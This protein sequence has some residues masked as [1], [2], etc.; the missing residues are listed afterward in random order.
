MKTFFKTFKTTENIYQH[1]TMGHR[2][3]YSNIY[4]CEKALIFLQFV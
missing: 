3:K 2:T 1:K 4:Y